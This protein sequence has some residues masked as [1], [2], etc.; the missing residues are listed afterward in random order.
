MESFDI[1]DVKYRD[2]DII[3]C[4]IKKKEIELKI[5]NLKREL[6]GYNEFINEFKELKRLIILKKYMI[7]QRNKFIDSEVTPDTENE[8]ENENEPS[9]VP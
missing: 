2:F 5:D 9:F 8:N 1:N 7:V 3:F 4:F 6:E